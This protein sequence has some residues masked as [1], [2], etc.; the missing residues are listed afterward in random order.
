MK[1]ETFT[2]KI[3]VIAAT[4]G[5][6]IGLGN[7]WSFPYKAGSN[8]GGWFV[9]LYIFFAFAIGLPLIISEFIIGRNG[10]DGALCAF[11]NIE[12]S[13]EQKPIK[14]YTILGG[15]LPVISSFIVISFYCVVAGWALGYFFIGIFK[16][17]GDYTATNS[18]QNFSDLINNSF[19]STALQFSF[20]IM[21]LLVLLLGVKNGIEKIAKIAMPI[22]L[23]IILVLL[24][25]ALTTGS[26]GEALSFLFKPKS[27]FNGEKLNFIEVA[28]AALSQAFFSLS[29]GLAAIITYG[30]YTSKDENISKISLSVVIAD[31]LVAILAGLVIFPIIFANNIDPSAGAGTAFIS[32]PIAFNNMGSVAGRIIGTLFFLLLVLA[33]ITSSISVLENCVTAINGKFKLGRKKTAIFVTI[34]GMLLGLL[35]QY[36]FGIGLPFEIVGQTE[37]LDQLD[38][39]TRNVTI[40]IAALTTTI[41]V[42]YRVKKKII[43]SELN[44]ERLTRLFIPYIRYVIPVFVGVIFIFG[45]IN[46]F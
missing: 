26:F 10:R 20:I 37:L 46:L 22:L 7:I 43:S 1:K 14:T 23:V 38:E 35:C 31:T 15:W 18:G 19:T 8:G 12:K 30:N 41:F 21:T 13:Q 32:L 11:E 6:A 9:I 27:T 28:V 39:F 42:G 17:F 5:A 29:I 33:A 3:A 16:G 44:N 45:L 4:A 24:G 40:P 34:G 25:Y 36:A 2:G